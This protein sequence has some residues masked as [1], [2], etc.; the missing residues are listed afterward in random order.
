MD[1]FNR[2]K[3]EYVDKVDDKTL[4][5]GAID[6]MLASLDPH[7]AYLDARGFRQADDHDRRQL[8]RPRPHRHDGGRR[9]QGRSRRP[10]DTPGRRAPG[11]KSGDYITHIDGNL[12]YGGTLDEAVERDARQSRH[13]DH[14]SPSSAPAA[15]S[16]STSSITRAIIESRSRSTGRSKDDVGIINVNTFSRTPPTTTQRGD[17]RHRQASSAIRRSAMSSTSAPIRAAC[18]TRRSACPTCSSSAARSSRSAA[19]AKTDIE[20]YYAQ[21]GDAAHGLPVDRAGRRRHRLGLGDRRRRAPGPSPR[22]RHGRAQLRQGLGPDPAAARQR[23]TALRL[24][25]ARYYTPSGRSVQEGGI[26]PDIVVPQLTD[27]DY[28]SR[29]GVPRGRPAPPP[30]QRGRRRAT[31][32]IEDDGQ[33]RSALRRDGRAAEGAGHRRLPARLRAADDRAARRGS[34]QPPQIARRAGPARRASR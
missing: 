19:A 22:D 27:P 1:V 14:A 31:I 34:Q 12:I 17:R 32:V 16:R 29:A 3:A 23:S 2:V 30:D 28:K 7:S 33:A 15:T 24:T 21:P 4:I 6:G 25:T 13:Q 5:K 10:E 8:W 9:G 18:S 11:I 20:R 26:A